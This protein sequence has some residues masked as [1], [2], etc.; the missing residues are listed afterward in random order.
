VAEMLSAICDK[1]NS[2]SQQDAE[3]SSTAKQ[4]LCAI[5]QP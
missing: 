4:L 1:L 3:V 2:I 5:K